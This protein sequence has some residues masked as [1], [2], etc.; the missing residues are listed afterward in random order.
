MPIYTYKAKI[1]PTT[2]RTGTIEAENEKA[3]VNKLLLLN[4]HPV[5]LIVKA[6][7]YSGR[8]NLFKKITAKDIYIFLRQLANLCI[9]GLPLV[10]ALGNIT[11][12]TTN[13]KLR[14]I[15][16]DVKENIQ[17]GKTF[18]ESLSNHAAVFSPLEISMVKSAEATGTLAEVISKIADLKE[19]DI[20]FTYRIRSAL[21]YPVLLI[22]VGFLTLFIL[23]TFVLPKFAVLFQDMGQKLPLSTQVLINTSLF[24]KRFWILIILGV[25][26]FGF[27]FFNYLKTKA[28]RMWFD[29][30]S[31]KF[32]FLGAV[33]IKVQTARF[34][35]MLATLIENGVPIINALQIVSDIA[36]NMVFAQELR[37]VYAL[38]A[39][40]YHI[41]EALR[42]G[43]AFEKNTLDLIAIGEESGRMEE[44]L[45]R[46]A[47]INET[48]SSQ[49]IETFILMLEPILILILGFIILFIVMAILL[50]IFQMDILIQ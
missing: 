50:P 12:Q 30:L 11:A 20:A 47:T 44:M 3:A 38:V 28:G 41:S 34:A 24:F 42:S 22:I 13:H 36:T 14:A 32:P 31:L 17:K 16:A 46:I 43:T 19:K 33:L 15:I 6:E 35:R 2:V 37:H 9:A 29:A 49:Q 40:G 48:E 1:N 27:S 26:L 10:K 45:F 7:T 39:K 5:S 23:T 21:T 18:S 25:F 4:Y 8:N